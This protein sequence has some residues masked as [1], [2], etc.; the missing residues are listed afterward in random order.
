ME[1]NM[2][3]LIN[4]YLVHKKCG[5]VVKFLPYSGGCYSCKKC[6]SICHS[7][8]VERKEFMCA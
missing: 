5:G 2:V 4:Y 8:V 1:G 3:G 7:N 6:N